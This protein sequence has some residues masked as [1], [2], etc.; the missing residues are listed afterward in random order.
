MAVR[1]EEL[2]LITLKLEMLEK[3]YFPISAF[4]EGTSS[5]HTEQKLS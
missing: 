4:Y 5:E 3:S 2:L 1:M